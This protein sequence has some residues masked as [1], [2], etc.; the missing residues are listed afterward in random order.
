MTPERVIVF[1]LLALVLIAIEIIVSRLE[2]YLWER[3]L[4]F[5]PFGFS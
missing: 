1:L 2:G 4:R 5:G 3:I